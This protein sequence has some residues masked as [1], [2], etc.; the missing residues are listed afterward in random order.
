MR[1]RIVRDRMGMSL[2]FGYVAMASESE[3]HAAIEALNGKCIRDRV[4]LIVHA[5]SPPLPRRV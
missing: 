4:F 3:A 1:A 2:G 5:D